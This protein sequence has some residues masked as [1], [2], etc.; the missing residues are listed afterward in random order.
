MAASS[1]ISTESRICSSTDMRSNV[2][3]AMDSRVELPAGGSNLV[4]V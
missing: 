2:R 4:D 3:V 1:R